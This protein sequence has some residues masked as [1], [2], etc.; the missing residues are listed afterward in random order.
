VKPPPRRSARSG[1]P[2]EAGFPRKGRAANPI[3]D[4]R[5]PEPPISDYLARVE[6]EDRRNHEFGRV[7]TARWKQARPMATY[8]T[9]NLRFWE[10]MMMEPILHRQE[11]EIQEYER[12]KIVGK[13]RNPKVI[14]RPG[15]NDTRKAT[16]E[17]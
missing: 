15:L 16:A 17:R 6:D 12:Q 7:V 9:D 8:K 13:R 11:R 10:K 4:F 2:G 3:P 1:R 14:I 5:S